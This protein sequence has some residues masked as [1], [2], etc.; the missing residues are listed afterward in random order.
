MLGPFNSSRPRR[1]ATINIASLIDVM[2]LLLIF[3]MASSTF[4][5]PLGID[6]ELPEAHTAVEQSAPEREILVD[7]EGRFHWDDRPVSEAGLRE[8]LT[9]AV[10]ANG[11]GLVSVVLRAD[12]QAD[13]GRVIRAVDIARAVGGARLI[14]PT[15][16]AASPQDP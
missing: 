4:R 1:R 14:I 16:P 7:R 12:A 5:N 6:L 13:F 9:D 11:D 8:A 2:F 15:Q 10:G 3:F